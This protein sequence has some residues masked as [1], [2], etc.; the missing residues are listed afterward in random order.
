MVGGDGVGALGG[1]VGGLVGG[2]FTSCSK[3][4]AFCIETQVPKFNLISHEERSN[5]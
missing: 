4:D 2:G 1:R 3:C 5:H